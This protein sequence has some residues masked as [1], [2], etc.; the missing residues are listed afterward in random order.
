M[1]EYAENIYR[2]AHSVPLY[3]TA[4]F[5]IILFWNYPVCI[6]GGWTRGDGGIPSNSFLFVFL[7]KSKTWMGLALFM[8]NINAPP[9]HFFFSLYVVYFSNKAFIAV[10][11]ADPWI[12]KHSLIIPP[13]CAFART[14]A[15]LRHNQVCMACSKTHYDDCWVQLNLRSPKFRHPSSIGG[16][17]HK[18]C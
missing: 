4:H 16:E 1:T 17:N 3:I 8:E 5:F 18:S 7:D 14:V 15:Y 13:L 12:I 10:L 6:F 2:R 9:F 11:I